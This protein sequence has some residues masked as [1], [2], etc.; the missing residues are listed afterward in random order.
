[1]SRPVCGEYMLVLGDP[2]TNRFLVRKVRANDDE[3]RVLPVE[4]HKRADRLVDNLIF[5]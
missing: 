4:S 3:Q 2:I 5:Q 1:V